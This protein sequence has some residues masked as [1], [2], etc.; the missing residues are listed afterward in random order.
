MRT[1]L[2]IRC[3]HHRDHHKFAFGKDAER[4]FQD[5]G[6][7]GCLLLFRAGI[8]ASTSQ[9]RHSQYSTNELGRAVR[10]VVQ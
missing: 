6:A 9:S 7:K 2:N 5:Q 1:N 10:S 4:V 8:R 3:V